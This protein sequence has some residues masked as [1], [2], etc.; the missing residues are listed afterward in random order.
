[1]NCK[2]LKNIKDSL[3]DTNSLI[4]SGTTADP[5]AE[6]EY[7]QDNIQ[8]NYLDKEMTQIFDCCLDYLC[9]WNASRTRRAC[10]ELGSIQL[11][12]RHS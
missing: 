4:A 6:K 1:M 9:Q 2:F 8:N 7:D 11:N 12:I 3:E 10:R 5:C